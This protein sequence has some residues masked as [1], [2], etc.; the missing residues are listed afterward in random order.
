M[1][2]TAFHLTYTSRRGEVWDWY[3]KRWRDRLWRNWFTA[4]FV[5]YA[6]SLFM[7]W[8]EHARLDASALGPPTVLTAV[9][10]LFF[11]AFPQIAFK[12]QVRTLTV[13]ERG[14]KTQIGTKS[15]ALTWHEISEIRDDGQMI[16][17][18]VRKTGNAFLVPERAFSNRA[19]RD[20]FLVVVRDWYSKARSA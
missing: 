14:V 6:V 5:I 10:F 11:T 3:W 20:D 4:A 1:T 15:A 9:V 8:Q 17:L 16:I 12:P 2:Q 7:A 19:E 18:L 13:D